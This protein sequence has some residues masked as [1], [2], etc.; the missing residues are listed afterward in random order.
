VRADDAGRVD[1]AVL[2]ALIDVAPPAY[3]PLLAAPA[4]NSTVSWQVNFCGEPV[5]SPAEDFWLLDADTLAADGG[6][7]SSTTRVWDEHGALRA[8]SHQLLAEFSGGR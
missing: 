5:D 8:I 4:P 3:A 6:Y 2:A 7:S 1:S